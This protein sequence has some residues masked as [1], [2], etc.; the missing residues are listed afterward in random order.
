MKLETNR[1]KQLDAYLQQASAKDEQTLRLVLKGTKERGWQRQVIETH[2]RNTDG[3]VL[4]R[5]EVLW[6]NRFFTKA[7]ET[8]RV[9][10]RLSK[11][12]K[13]NFKVN[14]VRL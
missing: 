4:T 7:S 11:K 3:K 10:I 9:P 12:E 14:P 1:E 5:K 6:K 13:E 2:T 8:G